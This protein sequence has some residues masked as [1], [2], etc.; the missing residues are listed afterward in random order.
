MGASSRAAALF[1]AIVLLP[2]CAAAQRQPL[3]VLDLKVTAERAPDLQRPLRVRLFSN[4][5]QEL[6][7]RLTGV[8]SVGVDHVVIDAGLATVQ[9]RGAPKG[10]PQATF[11][12]DYDAPPVVDLVR[13]LHTRFGK[14]PSNEQLIQF[15]RATLTPSG[16]RSFDVASQV[17]TQKTGDCTE[18]AVL[19]VAL[20]RAQGLPARVAIGT[21]IARVEGELGAFG[22]AW[23]EIYRDGAWK[24]V[25]A[26]PL[27][28]GTQVAYVPEGLLEDEGPG[29]GLGIMTLLSSGILRVEVIGNAA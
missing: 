7:S 15:V 2:S 26:T 19:L 20:A 12:I 4:S 8:V 28:G 29:Y 18:H 6:A 1:A 25:D 24:V 3:Y 21:L 5:P 11:V 17:A 27:A 13:D 22:H 14:S 16:A 9:S 23:A 10:P